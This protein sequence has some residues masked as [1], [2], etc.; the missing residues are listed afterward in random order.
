MVT[1][2]ILCRRGESA[3]PTLEGWAG[4]W[5]AANAVAASIILSDAATRAASRYDRSFARI[6]V[7]PNAVA[8]VGCFAADVLAGSLEITIVRGNSVGLRMAS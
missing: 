4:S 1:V 3:N 7:A 2:P 5:G 8:L 6:F